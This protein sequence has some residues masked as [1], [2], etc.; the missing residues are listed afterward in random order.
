MVK[1]TIRAKGNSWSGRG[2]V[3]TSHPNREAATQELVAYVQRNWDELADYVDDPP[4]FDPTQ[5]WEM[6]D[7]YFKHVPESYSFAERRS[8]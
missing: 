5:P 6:I 3:V 4:D 1:L 7:L 8:K 2:P